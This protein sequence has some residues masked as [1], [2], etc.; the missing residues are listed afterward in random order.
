MFRAHAKGDTVANPNQQDQP[1]T[2]KNPTSDGQHKLAPE[3]RVDPDSQV[4]ENED[5]SL[6]D[7]SYAFQEES[8]EDDESYD[9]DEDEGRI[10]FD[11]DDDFII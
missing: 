11:N 8:T 1:W 9:V 5:A 3:E 2:E 6:Q 10:D 7:D 4:R